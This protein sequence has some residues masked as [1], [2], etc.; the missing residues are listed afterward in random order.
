MVRSALD[1]LGKYASTFRDQINA[2]VR[3]SDKTVKELLRLNSE[4]DWDFLCASMDIIEDASEAVRHV[5]RFGLSGPTKYNDLGEIY[6]RLYGLLGATYIQQEAIL[7]IYR[8]MSDGNRK[9]LKVQF[10]ALEI[11]Q[12]RHKLSAHGTSYRKTRS[13]TE[14]AYV[15]LRYKIEDTCV[16]AVNNTSRQHETID[17]TEALEKHIRLVIETLDSILETSIN[18]LYQGQEVKTAKS[19]D[20]LKDLRIEK[21]GGIVLDIPGD[22]KIVITFVSSDQIHHD[23]A[24]GHGATPES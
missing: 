2:K 18:R 8:I 1:L 17:L 19:L 23:P 4:N 15:P 3:S 10:D 12:L 7:T 9:A 14:E 6:L 24:V 11:R 16:T 13:D 20:K 21:N 5:Q 22:K